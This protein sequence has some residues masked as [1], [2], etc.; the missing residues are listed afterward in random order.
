MK[1]WRFRKKPYQGGGGYE[2]P[3]H[4]KESRPPEIV[5]AKPDGRQPTV[6]TGNSAASPLTDVYEAPSAVVHTM[7][8][9]FADP[10]SASKDSEWH[11]MASRIDTS[12]I[13][14]EDPERIRSSSM[15][16]RSTPYV[17]DPERTML[18]KPDGLPLYSTESERIQPPLDLQGPERSNLLPLM[19]LSS[20]E[21]RF[22]TADISPLN[23]ENPETYNSPKSIPKNSP[24]GRITVLPDLLGD[25]EVSESSLD[26]QD[27]QTPLSDNSG[28]PGPI[29]DI[30]GQTPLSDNPDHPGPIFGIKEH[31]EPVLDRLNHPEF[32]PD[33]PDHP[34]PISDGQDHPHHISQRP[35]HPENDSDVENYPEAIPDTQSRAESIKSHET[36]KGMDQQPHIRREARL[37]RLRWRSLTTRALVSEKRSELQQSRSE[38]SDADAEFV[39]LS[40][41]KWISGSHDD[42]ALEA[43]FKK[44]QA[45]RDAYGPLEEAYNTLEER[46]DREEYEIAELEKKMFKNGVPIPES[47]NSDLESQSN[48]S[49]E[50]DS[51][52]LEI[53]KEQQNPLY[54]EFMSRLGDSGL[55]H[56][57][58]S[59]LLAEHDSL[60]EALEVSQKYDREL[61]PEDHTTLAKFYG[62]EAKMLEELR[63]IDADVERLRLECVREGLLAGEE[64]DENDILQTSN[65]SVDPEQAEYNRYPRLLTRPGEDEDERISK[66]LLSEFKSGDTGDRITRW[67]LHKLRS[68]CSEVELL[69][70][71]TDG[72]DRTVDTDKWQEEVLYFWFVDSSNLPPSAYEVEPTLTAL[73]SSDLT[74]LS[75]MPP[76]RFGE[77]QLIQLV[78]RSSSLSHSLEFGMLLKLARMKGRS[79]VTTM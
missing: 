14:I 45:T 24:N 58:Y 63:I 29:F 76:K 12:L 35:E 23:G 67:L 3:H 30:Q 65:G 11:Q 16:G 51:E 32:I 78:V 68:S 39:K 47:H 60:L 53:I 70:R 17:K 54:K 73:P 25:V 71:F 59:H 41:Q 10:E 4:V 27:H 64:G 28:H 57:A 37:H 55:L 7:S 15:L 69:A 22:G 36:V 18:S 40:R 33:E 56:E 62:K 46:L 2:K 77:K 1:R 61:Q 13:N 31:L 44:L 72:L 75:K 34:Q 43:S 26:L 9:T 48:S 38:M 52:N 42:L 50:D 19:E 20:S 6:A 5:V 49:D 8:D 79:A 66:A 74:D 21:S